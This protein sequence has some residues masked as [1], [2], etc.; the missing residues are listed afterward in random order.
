MTR[1]GAEL[2]GKLRREYFTDEAKMGHRREQLRVQ[3][4]KVEPPVKLTAHELHVRGIAIL[5]QLMTEP[6]GRLRKA[7]RAELTSLAY[8]LS[9]RAA[10]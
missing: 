8:A 4:E 1:A 2:A 6:D 10:K 5:T 3:G 7:L 9:D